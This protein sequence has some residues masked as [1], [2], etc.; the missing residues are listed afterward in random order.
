MFIWTTS[1]A[2]HR[3]RVGGMWMIVSLS[4]SR[5]YA[6]CIRQCAYDMCILL[7]IERQPSV[8]VCLR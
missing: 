8:Y 5:A 6:M 2:I 7:H 4:A 3:V 1:I